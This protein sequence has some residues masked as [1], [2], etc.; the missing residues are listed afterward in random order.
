[1]GIKFL[2][3]IV[4]L[5]SQLFYN[6]KAYCAITPQEQFVLDFYRWY[7]KEVS[8]DTERD[9]ILDNTILKYVDSRTIA[10]LRMRYERARKDPDYLIDSDYFMKG[11]DFWPELCNNITAHDL[12]VTGEG[13]Y[14]IH[15]TF[16]ISKDNN[17]TVIVFVERV[18][19]S[20]YIINVE[21]GD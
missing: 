20:F 7:C 8:A 11:N 18:N 14:T 19:N 13:M 5:F 9:P 16:K 4:I 3:F 2:L 1:M 15:V 12:T 10:R 21:R 6:K 17:H